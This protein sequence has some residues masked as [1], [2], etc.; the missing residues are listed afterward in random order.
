MDRDCDLQDQQV[1]ADLE[2]VLLNP[3]PDYCII[4]SQ[5]VIEFRSRLVQIIELL[6]L[7]LNPDLGFIF[8]FSKINSFLSGW[9]CAVSELLFQTLLVLNNCLSKGRNKIWMHH[10]LSTLLPSPL[11]PSFSVFF[12][13]IT[14]YQQ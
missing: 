13:F 3:D 8:P 11:T 12:P 1:I 5:I 6:L 2:L 10:W 7:F 14:L 9:P 4:Q